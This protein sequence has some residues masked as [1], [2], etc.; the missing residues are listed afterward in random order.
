MDVAAK[1][2]YAQELLVAKTAGIVKGV[3]ENRFN[4][5]GEISRQDMMVMLARAMDAQ[6]YELSAA[7]ASVLAEYTDS[8]QVAEYARE[9]VSRLVKDGVIAGEH[10]RINP[11]GK[12]T[13]AE[14]AVTLGRIFLSTE[15]EKGGTQ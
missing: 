11:L 3:G 14:V 5:R 13:R 1:E 4:P 15:E 6:E 12:A 8:A 10:G 7:D 9:A 2:Y